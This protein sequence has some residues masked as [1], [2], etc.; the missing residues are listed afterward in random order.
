MRKFAWIIC[1]ST[2]TVS[3]ELRFRKTVRFSERIIGSLRNQDA[4]PRTTSIKK[5][6]LYF[7]YES[8]DTLKSFSFVSQCSNY[9]ETESGTR[10]NTFYGQRRIWAFHVVGLQWTAKKCTKNY[11]ARAEPLFCSLNFLFSDV[12]VAVA[13]VVFVNSLMSK[14]KLLNIFAPNGGF[15][16]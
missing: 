6:I 5:M 1:S 16:V 15:C 2:L 4:T 7:T 8:R 12:R 3:L 13:V 10:R 14:D 9:N 11:N